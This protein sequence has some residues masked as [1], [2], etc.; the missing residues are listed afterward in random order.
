MQTH[1]SILITNKLTVMVKSSM[2]SHVHLPCTYNT[3]ALAVSSNENLLY[4][5]TVAAQ[6]CLEKH[7]RNQ[8]HRQR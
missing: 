8:N 6:N 4:I 5:L 2:S 1:F 7:K 3:R